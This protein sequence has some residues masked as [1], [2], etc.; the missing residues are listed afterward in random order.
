MKLTLRAPEPA[1]IDFMYRLENELEARRW[2]DTPGPLSRRALERFVEAYDGEIAAGGQLR[3]IALSDELMGGQP[4]A[5]VDLYNYDAVNLRAF[6]GITVDAQFRHYGVGRAC[7]AALADEARR[8]LDLYQ[9]VAIVS[10]ENAVSQRLFESAGYT[11]QGRLPAW[12]RRG[13]NFADALIYI[14]VLGK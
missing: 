2:S 1:D 10:S 14:C 4:L 12:L 13:L 8:Q 11:C 5:I 6:V 7:L 9:L 3:Y